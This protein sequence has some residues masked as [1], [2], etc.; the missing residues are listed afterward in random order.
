MRF[1]LSFC[2]AAFSS[3]SL[4]RSSLLFFFGRVLWLRL[5]KSILPSTLT[6]VALSIFFSLLVTKGFTGFVSLSSD[7]FSLLSETAIVSESFLSSALRDCVA[8][9]LSTSFLT[10]FGF[11][12][13]ISL[14][15]GVTGTGFLNSTLDSGFSSSFIFFAGMFS[16][17]DGCT[18]TEAVV[19]NGVLLVVSCCL[20]AV[21]WEGVSA[22]FFSKV[23]RSIFPR[24][25][26]CWRLISDSVCALVLSAFS[27]CFLSFVF[28][29]KIFAASDF[30]SLSFLNCSTSAEYCSS[31]SLKLGSPLTSPSSFFFSRNSTAVCSPMLSS[32]IALFNLMLTIYN[33]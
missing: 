9:T 26:N 23:L 7:G 31:L 5:L 27:F 24:G 15:S 10:S 21:S 19:S 16:G 8:F 6:F 20:S 4:L 29:W 1:F 14:C 28:F 12:A 22:G 25:L 13:I 18:L 2:C 3:R 17:A 33:F 11:G 30:T 32:L